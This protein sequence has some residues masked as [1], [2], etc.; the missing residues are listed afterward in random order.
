MD[1]QKTDSLGSI[2]GLCSRMDGSLVGQGHGFL[3][4]SPEVK[5]GS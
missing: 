3:S 5:C 1:M 4:S 2:L